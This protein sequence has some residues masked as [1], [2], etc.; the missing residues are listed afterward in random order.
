MFL[1]PLRVGV[2]AR[3]LP[4]GLIRAYVARIFFALTR[5]SKAVSQ[6]AHAV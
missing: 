1:P 5:W 4:V 3:F 2:M 6:S